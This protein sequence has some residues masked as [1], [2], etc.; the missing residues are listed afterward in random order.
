M[1]AHTAEG[2]MTNERMKNLGSEAVS[3]SAAE[4][5]LYQWNTSF[6]TRI[7]KN[8]TLWLCFKNHGCSSRICC[9]PCTKTRLQKVIM[10]LWQSV[11]VNRQGGLVL[12]FSI[13]IKPC[14]LLVLPQAMEGQ[15]LT[16]LLQKSFPIFWRNQKFQVRSSKKLFSPQYTSVIQMLR[17]SKS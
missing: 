14:K 13:G 11:F 6:Y 5:G 10:Y 15:G 12:T 1:R 9:V 4:T 8:L 16:Q 17:K 3:G 7:Q 2:L